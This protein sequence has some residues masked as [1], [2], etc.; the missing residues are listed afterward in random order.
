MKAI[1]RA[2]L[3]ALFTGTMAGA[4]Q[5]GPIFLTG[6]DPDFHAGDGLGD[7]A[8]LLDVGLSFVTGGQHG[9]STVKFLWVQGDI[10]VPSGHT[11]PT[12]PG[13]GGL[14]NLGLVEGTHYDVAHAADLDCGDSVCVDFGD[15]EAIA[16]GSAFGGLFTRAELD[17]LIA[18]ETDIADFINAGGGLFAAAECDN[19]GA[20]LLGSSPDLFG[21]VPLTGIVSVGASP[22][23]TVTAA[24]AAA[25]FSLTNADVNDPTHNSFSSVPGVLQ[26]LDTDSAGNATTIAGNVRI[27]DGGFEGVPEP[28]TTA[29][30]GLGLAALGL[31]RRRKIA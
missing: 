4:A 7:G 15:Y 17:A 20:D 27:G 10:S 25:P 19:C 9:D 21:F 13:T 14:S 28:A 8:T 22:P 31:A 12:A 29:L 2:L 1:Q 18:R 3:A 16:V 6:H 5:A 11:D 23:F 24:G 30:L 26:I